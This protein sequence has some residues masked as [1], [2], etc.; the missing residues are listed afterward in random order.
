MRQRIRFWLKLAAAIG[1]PV[2]IV[3][4]S[5]SSPLMSEVRLGVEVSFIET[6][7]TAAQ[8]DGVIDRVARAQAAR[9]GQVE[10]Y[11][12]GK[13]FD[14]AVTAQHRLA[15][16]DPRLADLATDIAE[17]DRAQRQLAATTH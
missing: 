8:M 2:S 6:F 14:D 10:F 1:L 9:D 5:S 11:D 4:A 3:M 16:L 17:K 7:G 12:A 15:E 13:A